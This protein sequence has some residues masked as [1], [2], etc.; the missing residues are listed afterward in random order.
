MSEFLTIGQL[1]EHFRE[2]EWKVRRAVDSLAVAVPRAGL[3]RLVPVELL[4]DVS[5]RLRVE[6]AAAEATR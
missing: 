5:R 2:P 3:Y 6:S 1:A 4:D